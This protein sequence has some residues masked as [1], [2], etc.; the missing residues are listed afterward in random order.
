[1]NDVSAAAN[2]TG[3]SIW[4]GLPDD[5]TYLEYRAMMEAYAALDVEDHVGMRVMADDF[6]GSYCSSLSWWISRF[7]GR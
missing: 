1:M 3:K 4:L 6:H 2:S 7:T 5:L